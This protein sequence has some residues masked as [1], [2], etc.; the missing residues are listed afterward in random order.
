MRSSAATALLIGILLLLNWCHEHSRGVAVRI[1]NIDRVPLRAVVVDVEGR[2]YPLGDFPPGWKLD[3]YVTPTG[4]SDI[5]I[6][7]TDPAGRA[8]HFDVLGYFERGYTG[9]VDVEISAQKLERVVEDI[10]M[11]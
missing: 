11:F 3:V 6:S 1:R 7:F 2:S 10:S 5:A 8:K 4:E 9:T